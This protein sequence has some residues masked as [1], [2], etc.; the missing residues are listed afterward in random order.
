MSEF[1]VRRRTQPREDLALTLPATRTRSPRASLL[2]G[3]LHLVARRA[4]MPA[5]DLRTQ[6]RAVLATGD[7]HDQRAGHLP[8]RQLS[9]CRRHHP[10]RG[11]RRKLGPPLAKKISGRL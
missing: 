1:V 11:R 2:K 10:Y 4:R 8:A 6:L 5:R 3:I 7:L 9:T